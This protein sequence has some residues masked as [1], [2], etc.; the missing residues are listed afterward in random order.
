MGFENNMRSLDDWEKPY[1]EK[2]TMEIIHIYSFG[3]APY[4]DPKLKRNFRHNSF[5]VGNTT[6]GPVNEGLADYT[7][8]SLSDVPALIPT[9]VNP[10]AIFPSSGAL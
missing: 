8:V 4:T 3:I 5:F 7:P 2:F 9:H 1:P 6:R 10:E